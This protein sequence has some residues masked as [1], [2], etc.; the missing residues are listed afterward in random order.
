M[1]KRM[2]QIGIVCMGVLALVGCGQ[3]GEK[4]AG[5]KGESGLSGELTVYTA[6]EEELIPTYLESF[7]EQYPNIDLNIVRDSTGIIT[8]KLLAEGKNTKADVVWGVQA[9]NLLTLEEKNML[10]EYS[11]EGV[12]EIPEMYRDSKD[13]TK[14]TGNLVT[15]SGITV[16]TAEL[17]EMGIEP[18]KTYKDLLDPKYKGLIAMPHPASSGTGYLQ[19]STWLQMM[20]KEKGWQYMKHLHK[21]VGIYTHSG[22]KPIKMAANGEFPISLGLVYSGIQ[23]K[24]NGAPVEVYLPKAGLGWD[25]EANALINKKNSESDKLAK[26]FLDWAV[27]DDVMKEYHQAYGLATKNEKLETAKGFPENFEDLLYKD[28]NLRQSAKQ[29]SEI[30]KQWEANFAE[31]AEPKK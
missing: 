7:E 12:E 14:W 17:K 26:A 9:S 8:S 18:P 6:I 30:L 29:R 1:K 21:N 28:H 31:K 16:N 11:P 25:V 27:S 15:A 24:Q 4:S 3:G 5:G 22:S 23:E 2:G 20:G 10:A 19:V 13:S